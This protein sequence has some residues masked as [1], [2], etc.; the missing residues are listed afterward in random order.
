M[1][2]CPVCQTEYDEEILR[3]CIKDG[4]PLVDKNQPNFKDIPSESDLGEDTVIRRKPTKSELDALKMPDE[5]S[6]EPAKIVIPTVEQERQ[7]QVRARAAA[8]QQPLQP[9][10]STGMVVLTT[11]VLTLVGLAALAGLFYFFKNGE[12]TANSNINV[13]TNLPN[14]QNINTNFGLNMPASN[15]DYNSNINSNF[16]ANFNFN[17]NTN[18]N[19]NV[20][21]PTPT[22]TPTPT[23]SPSP[24]VSPSAL[25]ANTANTNTAAT[26]AKTATPNTPKTPAPTPAK[27]PVANSS[28]SE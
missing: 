27:T 11:V 4:A 7:Q 6:S 9:P 20:K 3:F 2:F 8:Y 23:P 25:P 1:K 16:N 18:S 13:N 12:D 14:S 26:P 24:S 10:R 28:P 5:K 19:T 15:F 22:R 17:L 21:T